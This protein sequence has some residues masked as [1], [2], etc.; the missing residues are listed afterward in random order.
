MDTKTAAAIVKS[1]RF[2]PNAQ[3]DRA[4]AKTTKKEWYAD[5]TGAFRTG[6]WTAEPGKS[7]INYVSDE[8][9]VILDGTVRLTDASGHVETYHAGDT[10]LI[11]R[12]FI[13]TWETVQPVRKFYAVHK[14]SNK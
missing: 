10:F 5:H 14:S 8:L 7:E 2:D 12:G 4:S 9:C 3:G 1:I 11:P 6:I 13:G